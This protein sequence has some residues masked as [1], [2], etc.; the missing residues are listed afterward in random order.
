MHDENFKK[1]EAVDEIRVSINGKKFINYFFPLD[2]EPPEE[3]GALVEFYRLW[4][5]CCAHEKI[6]SRND[7]PF[8]K[9]VGWHSNIRIVDLENSTPEADKI[10][11][12]GSTF[13]DYFGK[14]TMGTE[15]RS[16]RNTDPKVLEGYKLFQDYIN[17]GYYGLV[18]GS[19]PNKDGLVSKVTW[20][21][22]PLS[23]DGEVIT[24]LLSALKPINSIF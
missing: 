3:T 11:I 1:F 2:Q 19:P 22:L 4:R 15:I 7:L 9:L 5:S 8:E 12:S 14:N 24:H 16:G 17:K 13:D 18:V 23:N 21:D 10:V 20:L 6:P